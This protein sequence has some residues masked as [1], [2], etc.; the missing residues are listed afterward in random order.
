MLTVERSHRGRR[1]TFYLGELLDGYLIHIGKCIG[2]D[3][4]HDS[5]V[6]AVLS[7][8]SAALELI[9]LQAEP[10]RSYL[11]EDAPR[12]QADLRMLRVLCGARRAQRDQWPAGGCGGRRAVLPGAAGRADGR[13]LGRPA[14]RA[15]RPTDGEYRHGESRRL[16]GIGLL[17]ASPEW[18]STH[19]STKCNVSRILL[20][21]AK[22]GDAI[23]QR[24]VAKHKEAVKEM[25]GRHPSIQVE[26][27]HGKG[28]GRLRERIE[29]IEAEERR[30]MQ[31]EERRHREA[32]TQR[33]RPRRPR[34]PRRQCSSSSSS[35]SSA[36]PRT[37]RVGVGS[38][39]P[40]ARAVPHRQ[41]AQSM[42]RR[43]VARLAAPRRARAPSPSSSPSARHP[44]L[45]PSPRHP[46]RS[47]GSRRKDRARRGLRWP[48]P[49]A[50]AEVESRPRRRQSTA[51][52]RRAV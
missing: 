48:K 18:N 41:A 30:R 2:P 14:G 25:L 11:A 12:L 4:I 16:G 8:L 44:M 22:G 6:L 23:A 31:D 29:E 15:L 5:L 49:G 32:A 38:F 47:I 3:S 1:R 52:H 7:A 35:S 40:A 50:A 13:E 19:P 24:F 10:R 46:R 34:W 42:P 45:T 51:W 26:R 9:L 37:P 36:R 17:G 33:R 21:R 43:Q 39:G 20:D 27:R 28:V